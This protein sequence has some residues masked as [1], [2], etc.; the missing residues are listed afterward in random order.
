MKYNLDTSGKSSGTLHCRVPT[1][2]LKLLDL[3]TV[4][5]NSI[6]PDYLL[7]GLP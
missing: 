2:L 4:K 3:T 1:E 6:N 5:M 7:I